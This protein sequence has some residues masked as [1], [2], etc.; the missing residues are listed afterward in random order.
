[1]RLA[2]TLVFSV[3]AA[4]FIVGGVAVWDA[5]GWPAIIFGYTAASCLCLAMGYA[6]IGPNVFAKRNTGQHSIRSWLLFSPYFL[7]NAVIFRLYRGTSREPAYAEVVPNLFFGRRLTQ[8]EATESRAHGWV[9]VLDLAP[10]FTET[11]ALRILPGYRSFPILDA[12]APQDPQLRDAVRWLTDAMAKGPVYVHCALGHG[13][14]GCVVVAYL[15]A[16]GVVNSVAE[17]VRLLRVQRP[18]VRLNRSQSRALR[19]LTIPGAG[20]PR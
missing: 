11:P 8:R 2:Y 5:I 3:L 18:G 1:M 14:T 12:T 19:P 6:W 9:T 15:L 16:A 13:R 10:E 7:L 17:G 4:V 20:F